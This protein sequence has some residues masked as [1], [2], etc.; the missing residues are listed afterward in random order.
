MLKLNF[1]RRRSIAL[2]G[3]A[4]ALALIATAN[5]QNAPAGGGGGGGAPPPSPA[6]VAL[7]NRKAA[8][9][10]IGNNFRWFGGVVRGNVAYDNAE[11]LKRAQRI[12]FLS[13]LPG[14][15]FPEGSSFPEPESKAKPEVW[16]NRADFDKKLSDFQTHAAALLDVVGKEKGA[17]EPFKAAVAAV[18]QDCKGC[19]DDYRVK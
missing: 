2:A 19:H 8:Y 18:A 1:V 17:T 3:S 6:K 5:A 15:N 12:V 7:E 16:T 11:A 9:T 14:E 4:A 10:L 13:A